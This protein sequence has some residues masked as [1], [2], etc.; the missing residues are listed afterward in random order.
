PSTVFPPRTRVPPTATLSPYPTLFRSRYRHADQPSRAAIIRALWGRI[1]EIDGE[2]AYLAYKYVWKAR[3]P[4]EEF[5]RKY[6]RRF[7]RL[8]SEGHTSALQARFDLVCRLL[9]D[10]QND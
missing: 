6:Y 1:R 10:I 2:D 5:Q 4:G 8:R 9:L 7:T 3:H